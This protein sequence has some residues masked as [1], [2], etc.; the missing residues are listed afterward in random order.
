[1]D[2]KISDLTISQFTTLVRRIV[3][4]ELNNYDP[5]EGLKV[6]NEVAALLN[7]SIKERKAGKQKTI[8]FAKAT[9]Y[10]HV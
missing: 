6:K 2:K 5:D 4:K 9:L 3:K 10:P 1:M 7:K 8:P